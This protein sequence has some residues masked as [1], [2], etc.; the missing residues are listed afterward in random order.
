MATRPS[1]PPTARPGHRLRLMRWVVAPV[2]L[3]LSGCAT[4]AK[5]VIE[6]E[7]PAMPALADAVYSG[8]LISWFETSWFTPC[9]TNFA[10]WF[11]GPAY[12]A[13]FR[14]LSE[15]D[16]KSGKPLWVRV[17]G[18]PS[19]TGHWGHLGRYSRR[20]SA[21]GVLEAREYRPG[22]CNGKP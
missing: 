5:I 13:V 2:V 19:A 16:R 15:H 21:R 22:D 18:T 6:P 17:T 8:R 1:R 10:W 3:A 20:L 12:G 4:P 9:G 7:P 11:E 14:L